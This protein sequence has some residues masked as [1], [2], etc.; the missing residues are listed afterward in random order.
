LRQF[1]RFAAKSRDAYY[2][3][4]HQTLIRN[5]G[6]FIEDADL[7]E[8]RAQTNM[9][10]HD[11]AFDWGYEGYWEWQ[12][13]IIVADLPSAK[14]YPDWLAP[15]GEYRLKFLTGMLDAGDDD[16]WNAFLSA[17]ESAGTFR[18]LEE[19]SEAWFDQVYSENPSLYDRYR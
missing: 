4:V 6:K 7:V 11:T 2:E 15:L 14:V 12:D 13:D 8:E 19:A 10:W 5:Y 18:V 17:M 1:G 16:D 3:D 9:D